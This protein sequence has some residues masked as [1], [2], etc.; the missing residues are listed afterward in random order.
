MEHVEVHPAN[1]AEVNKLPGIVD[2]LVEQGVQPE[3]VLANKGSAS[4]AN[5]GYLKAKG[6]GELIQFKGSQGNPVHP[7]Q[8]QMTEPSRRCATRS[9][10]ASGR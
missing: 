2:D 8:T 7:L 1:Q 10:R 3:G 9:S 5:R 4:A 6:I